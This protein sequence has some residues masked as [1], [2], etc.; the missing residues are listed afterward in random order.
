VS[1]FKIPIS[2]GAMVSFFSLSLTCLNA[3]SRI[4]YPMA[5]HGIFS[6]HLGKTHATNRT[7]HIAITVYIGM[8]V[9]IPAILEIFTN[10]LTAFGDVGTM[11]AFGFLLA[12][13]LITVAAPVYLKKLG[14][15]RAR[16]IVIA[17]VAFLCLMV[18]TIGSVYPLPAYP[19]DLF[20]VY[21][22][23]WMALGSVWLFIVHRRDPGKLRAIEADFERVTEFGESGIEVEDI[24]RET[25]PA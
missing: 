4:I 23:A 19:A 2:L 8:I 15:L 24:L 16:N 3:G 17:V 7:P 12:Y 1:A 20:P 6:G 18:P 11:A 14:E 22:L 25:V 5:R 9:V 21:F 13:F 10:P